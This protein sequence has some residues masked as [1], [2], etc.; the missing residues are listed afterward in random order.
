MTDA[1]VDSLERR[2]CAALEAAG[3]GAGA[4]IVVAVSGGPDSLALLHAL[5]RLR[6]RLGL[7]LHA[8]HLDHRL[9]GEESEADARFVERTCRGIDVPVTVDRADVPALRRS[10]GLSME[11]A[12]REARY[13]FLS[14]LL[15]AAWGGRRRDRPHVGRPGGDGAD[16][17]RQGGGVGRAPGHRAG[18]RTSL[19]RAESAARPAPAGDDRRGDRRLLPGAGTGPPGGQ[20]EP[21]HRYPAQ[22]RQA[23]SHAPAG[24]VQP[25]RQGGAGSSLG[26]GVP[27]SRLCGEPGGRAV[28][29]HSRG[30]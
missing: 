16:E 29:Q 5:S 13:A 19:R 22:S 7:Q 1:I 4:L 30:G 2:A 18:R 6:G 24:G 8:A 9:R 10:R 25:V 26:V 15:R 11:E 3:L 14:A 12:A 20:L 21:V 23:L 28:E 27:R 17:H